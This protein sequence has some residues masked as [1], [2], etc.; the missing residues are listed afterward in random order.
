MCRHRADLKQSSKLY[1]LSPRERVLSQGKGLVKHSITHTYSYQREVGG[2]TGMGQMTRIHRFPW[3]TADD[4]QVLI[5]HFGSKSTPMIAQQLR[6]IVL[7]IRV[8]YAQ[9]IPVVMASAYCPKLVILSGCD[10]SVFN[11]NAPTMAD[12]E[13]AV[14]MQHG[15]VL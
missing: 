6:Q 13:L 3:G 5:V 10:D 4:A 14:F 7:R 9:D 15:V 1:P 8:I 2:R 12:R 11:E